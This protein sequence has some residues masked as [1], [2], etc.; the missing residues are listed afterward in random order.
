MLVTLLATAALSTVPAPRASQV[1]LET[2]VRREQAIVEAGGEASELARLTARHAAAPADSDALLALATLDRFAYRDADAERAYRTLG[3]VA[4]AGDDPL[5]VYAVLGFGLLRMQEARLTDAAPL[6]SSAATSFERIGYQSGAAEALTAL[7]TVLSRT[8]S[9]DSAL[10][11]ERSALLASPANDA[12]LRSLIKC[13]TFL[14]LVRKADPKVVHD[15]R[16]TAAAAEAAGNPRAAGACLAALGQDYERR[17]LTDSALD[18][19]KEVETIERATRNFGVLAGIVQ[20][21]GYVLYALKDEFVPAR[22]LLNEAFVLGKRTSALTSAAWAAIGLSDMALTLGDLPASGSYARQAEA[23]FVTTGD[24]WGMAQ[25]RMHEGDVALL[26]GKLS[27][28]RASEEE[29]VKMAAAIAPTLA[30]HAHGRLAAIALQEGDPVDAERELDT[31]RR[32]SLDLRMTEWRQ[33]DAYG[34]A[35]VALKRGR[36]DEAQKRL[37]ALNQYLPPDEVSERSELFVRLAEVSM[38]RHDLDGAVKN[39]VVSNSLIDRWRATL[40]QRDLQMAVVQ[41]RRFDWDRDLSFATIIHELALSGRTS[42]AFT[43]SERRRARVL[44][45]HLA[46]RQVLARVTPAATTPS[47]LSDTAVSR[48]LPES[49]AV[50]AFVTGQGREPTT[51]FVVTR[52]SVAAASADPVDDHALEIDRF[53]GLLAGGDSATELGQRL[54]E[55]F[56]RPALVL[57]PRYVR[58]LVVIP[59]GPLY[60]LPFDAL[61]TGDRHPVVERFAVTLAPSASVAATWWANAPRA[62]AS[63]L[64]AFG[65]PV[66][67]TVTGSGGDS[68]PPRLP[69]AAEEARTIARFADD[70]DV[71]IGSD[72]REAT[73]RR[74][75]LSDVGV[76][77]FATH[78]D[79]D[80][81]SLLHS[82]LL[83][84]PGG[85]EDGRLG[86]DEL[87]GMH[88]PVNLVVLSACS[89]A[90]GQVLAGE[91]LQGLTSPFLE[92]GASSVVATLWQIDDRSA[93][94]FVGL[95]YD[96]LATGASVGTAL[97]LAKLRARSENI[98][99]GVWAAFTITGDDRV[100]TMLRKP[101]RLPLV[102]LTLRILLFGVVAYFASRTINRRNAD[103]R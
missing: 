74:A 56:L 15:A 21:R 84:A 38:R 103:R 44:L 17:T 8:Q 33:E 95:F 64:L 72:A 11:I 82:A 47:I 27:A 10:T 83:L 99:P 73:F 92:V 86:V 43:L 61:D 91:G 53:T 78:A 28:A 49:T 29:V 26:S 75:R 80:E 37:L 46:R 20:W 77:H 31:A 54:G 55:V 6:L 22:E 14:V 7:G 51:I 87:L 96:E 52:D 30:V 81:W 25:A 59:D 85:G 40:G 57:V 88:V 18:T 58:R 45:E 2:L 1:D 100:H 66:G 32:M 93:A 48:M 13:N 16:A 3:A 101:S 98:S 60:R 70:A 97:H 12:W 24:R 63:R 35:L 69:A 41:A 42:V 65:D 36:L 39:L 89:S 90:G 23:M 67:V 19:F 76:L 79:V 4:V 34:R 9:L 71:F 62:P 102:P 94:N 5:K 68:I 50:I